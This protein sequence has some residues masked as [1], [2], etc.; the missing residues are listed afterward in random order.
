MKKTIA[1]IFCASL[2]YCSLAQ[3]QQLGTSYLTT[4]V[5]DNISMDMDN[6]GAIYA[7]FKPFTDNQLYVKR[8]TGGSWV[9]VGAS[10]ASTDPIA[11]GNMVLGADGLPVVVYKKYNDSI[12]V[13]KF[14]GTSWQTVG[15]GPFAKG[16]YPRIAVNSANVIHVVFNNRA[17]FPWGTSVY[18]FEGGSWGPLH[19]QYIENLQS[20]YTDIAFDSNDNAVVSFRRESTG[21]MSVFKSN[22]TGWQTVGNAQFTPTGTY[23]G[24]L[25]I[26]NN[27]VPYVTFSVLASNNAGSVMY[28]NG[29]TWDY[30]GSPGFTIDPV[31]YSPLVFDDSNVPY[32]ALENGSTKLMRYESSSWQQ[33]DVSPG[34]GG[35]HDLLFNQYGNP[36]LAYTDLYQ[37]YKLI[38]KQLCS[39]VSTDQTVTICSGDVYE[40]GGQEYS[41]SG[42]YQ[43]TLTRAS[44][45]DSLINLTLNVLSVNS[46]SQEVAICSGETFQVGTSTYTQTGIY[47]TVLQSVSGCDSLVTTQLHVISPITSEQ[48]VT[49]CYGETLQVGTTLLSSPGTYSTVI[50]AASGCDSTVTTILSVLENI[51]SAQD[52]D[53][54]SG[55]SIQI[56]SSVYSTSGTYTDIFTAISGCDSTVTTTV[57][58]QSPITTTVTMIDLTLTAD[59]QN[60]SYQWIDCATQSPI[61]GETNQSFSPSV[62]GDYAVELTIGSCSAVSECMS[63]DVAALNESAVVYRIYP[64]PTDGILLVDAT[65][66][67][68]VRVTNMDGRILIDLNHIIAPHQQID[69]SLL[70][71]GKYIIELLSNESVF[72]RSV[73]VKR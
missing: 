40:I 24:R 2:Y 68:Q 38:A 55:E 71:S 41:V 27:D 65:H 14:D 15:A 29:S 28:L 22:G 33:V 58:V 30:L 50:Q 42:N 6:S 32:I 53:L 46:S 44:G 16:D 19:S 54:C 37:N 11:E 21:Q 17:V 69:L 20:S 31:D 47:T 18:K 66:Y 56:G 48:T 49:L 64:N 13:R 10:S 45:C 62:S 3:W 67:D 4:D 63:I 39:P 43:L 51:V 25:S 61:Q 34:L 7:A 59:Q 9:Q 73:V 57:N 12:V 35:E 8:Y 60:A 72:A 36:V 1:F 70:A 52:V 26:D 23:F 5:T